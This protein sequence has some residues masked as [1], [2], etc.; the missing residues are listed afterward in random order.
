MECEAHDDQTRSQLDVFVQSL[1]QRSSH[2]IPPDDLEKAVWEKILRQCDAVGSFDGIERATLEHIRQQAKDINSNNQLMIQWNNLQQQMQMG[3]DP[4]PDRFFSY[5]TPPVENCQAGVRFGAFLS[6]PSYG[7]SSSFLNEFCSVLS[8]L[9][10]DVM[11]GL[12]LADFSHQAAGHSCFQQ[13]FIARPVKIAHLSVGFTADLC[14]EFY[15]ANNGFF[16]PSFPSGDAEVFDQRTSEAGLA[17]YDHRHPEKQSMMESVYPFQ[18][19]VENL[20]ALVEDHAAVL[21]ELSPLLAS[22]RLRD[23]MIILILAKNSD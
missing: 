22:A 14:A 19:G 1:L 17:L 11:Q 23:E 15:H 16:D 9:P 10:I 6:W 7:S 12:R 5:C 21:T 20:R 18:A 3:S 2:S 13:Q 8:K 4:N